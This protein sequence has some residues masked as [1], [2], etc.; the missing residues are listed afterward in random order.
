MEQLFKKDNDRYIEVFPLNY[1]QSIIDS[2]SGKA[3][4]S[5]LNS[6]NNIYVP[7]QDTVENTRNMIP[8]S[9]RRKGLW[10]TYNNGIKY[11][12]EY[13]NGSVNDI[14]E[15][16]ADNLNWQVVPD[17]ELVQSEASKLPDGIITT[18]KLSPALQEL[19]KQNNTITN[20][21]DD[22]DLEEVNLVLKLK[23]RKYKPELASGKGY[24]ILR[25]NW[26]K[27]GGKMINLLTQDMINEANTIYEIRY[28]FDLNNKSIY[29]P[30]ECTLDFKG[31]SLKNGVIYSNKT[32]IINIYKEL[33]VIGKIYNIDGNEITIRGDVINRNCK[34]Y[35]Y[36]CP[37]SSGI[38]TA[39]RNARNIGITDWI[40]VL[41][42][43][44][45]ENENFSIEEEKQA[46]TPEMLKNS[47][48][49]NNIIIDAIKFHTEKGFTDRGINTVRA[50]SNFVYNYIV[51]CK[52]LN[53]EFNSVFIVN[54]ESDWT[55]STNTELR[56][57]IIELANKIKDLGLEPCISYD[58]VWS[59]RYRGI[60]EATPGINFYPTISYSDEK[61]VYSEDTLKDLISYYFDGLFPL[62]NKFTTKEV[63]L[64]ETGCC[65]ATKAL[66]TPYYDFNYNIGEPCPY[67]LYL[68]WKY[69]INL[70]NVVGLKYVCVWFIGQF[71]PND[72]DISIDTCYNIFKTL[73]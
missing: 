51:K 27:V 10:I 39:I 1:I 23:D 18:D 47:I 8:E 26:T 50:Y 35:S 11:I 64:S 29:I 40:C 28:D 2:E 17:L 70:V 43:V 24:K 15:H 60:Q 59:A 63:G 13:Y 7:Y 44:N 66:R 48:K 46:K 31:G 5:I 45:D 19:I 58:G 56:E 4:S 42:V 33:D 69:I 68:Y 62:L 55:S 3:L 32:K 20:L 52:E 61:S 38:D 73:K 65:G 16:W 21:P 22:E 9:M 57:C 37:I 30:E 36:W 71:D 53:I 14:K 34:L 6:F 54:E 41:H 25:K 12:T 72:Y 49:R 67:I